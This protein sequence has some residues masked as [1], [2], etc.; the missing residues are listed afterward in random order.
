MDCKSLIKNAHFQ[1]KRKPSRV[2]IFTI[3]IF[4]DILLNILKSS[5]L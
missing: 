1:K 5:E 2:S 3:I 4:V